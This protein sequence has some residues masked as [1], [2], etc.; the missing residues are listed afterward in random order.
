MT[1]RR[2]RLP[3]GWYP[4]R[5]R[6]ILDI[7]DRA[8]QAM[9]D[10]NALAAVSPHAGW[11][12]CGSLMG[13]SL[14]S[15]DEGARTLIVFGGH[16]PPGSRPRLAPEDA[17]ETPLG[18]IE[19][20]AGLRDALS[21]EME[22]EADVGVDNTVEVILPMLKAF[23]PEARLL[24]LRSPNDASA[25][26]LG[27]A[28]ARLAYG[29]GLRAAAIGS[30]DLTHYGEAYGFTPAGRGRQA[31]EWVREVN[32]ARIVKA[33]LAMDG[34]G[35]LAMGNRESAACSAGAA[36]S[37][38]AFA[39]EGGARAGS[40]NAYATSLDADTSSADEEAEQ[41]VGYASISYRRARD[42]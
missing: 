10:R 9:P 4:R 22:L 37:A 18:D 33:M 29:R 17:F 26:G 13:L 6:D 5:A 42:S 24:W 7:A 34:E 15:L 35:T 20:E 12:Y 1:T 41:F 21:G 8:R 31:L 23:F 27:R 32:D 2:M 16:L 25:A 36:L 39:A 40:L 28:V 30:T 11:Y 3:P 19:A 14:A 38:M